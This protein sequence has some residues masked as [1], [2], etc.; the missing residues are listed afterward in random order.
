VSDISETLREQQGRHKVAQE[1]DRDGQPG[2]VLDAH[3]RSTP[4]TISARSAKNAPVRITKRRSDTGLTPVVR[5]SFV[6]HPAS[7]Y[8]AGDEEQDS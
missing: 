4:F 5:W 1:K 8:P 3:S 6:G 7:L 2:C